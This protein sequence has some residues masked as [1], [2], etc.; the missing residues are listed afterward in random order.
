VPGI[1]E[2]PAGGAPKAR[3]TCGEWAS[4][5]CELYW[6]AYAWP[7]SAESGGRAFFINQEGDPMALAGAEFLG[8]AKAPPFGPAFE[9]AGGM[10][11]PL[12]GRQVNPAGW[13]SVD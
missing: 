3:M 9:L 6:C 1:G 5:N 4:D 11:A 2:A 8:L 10:A 12:V 7:L 13:V